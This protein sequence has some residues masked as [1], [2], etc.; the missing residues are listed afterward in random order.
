MNWFL[1]S[2]QHNIDKYTEY[3]MSRF[4]Y[5]MHQQRA[6]LLL[7]SSFLWFFCQQQL[8]PKTFP[9]FVRFWRWSLSKSFPRGHLEK[10]HLFE[11]TSFLCW[12]FYEYVVLSPQNIV[13]VYYRS[14]FYYGSPSCTDISI[15]FPTMESHFLSYQDKLPT[16]FFIIYDL[17]IA[18]QS[19]INFT[20]FTLKQNG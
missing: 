11:T 8:R 18:F 9:S 10:K 12:F 19:I 6:I 2:L 20:L 3:E 14:L 5:S 16:F 15:M 4:L 13:W 7:F 17:I 1:F